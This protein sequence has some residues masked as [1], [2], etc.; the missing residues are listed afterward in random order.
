MHGKSTLVGHVKRI[1]SHFPKSFTAISCNDNNNK[2]YSSEE[3]YCT[4]EAAWPY[5]CAEDHQESTMLAL[6]VVKDSLFG[7]MPLSSG[8]YLFCFSC[9]SRL[10]VLFSNIIKE[11]K[12]VVQRERVDVIFWRTFDRR[13]RY[14]CAS[15][16]GRMSCKVPN[17]AISIF[18]K[19]F[20]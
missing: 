9:R 12:R 16:T 3:E 17:G 10:L 13:G 15:R 20:Q 4:T 14:L 18:P 2:E 7:R 11:R 5:D 19:I 1:Q 8:R 6:P